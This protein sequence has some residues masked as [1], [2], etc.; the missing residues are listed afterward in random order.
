MPKA[1][2]LY[3]P[4]KSHLLS[5]SNCFVVDD[6]VAAVAALGYKP[7]HAYVLVRRVGQ[8][9][10]D[11]AAEMALFA[12][13][14][15]SLA[16]YV[17]GSQPF[18]SASFYLALHML[19]P[20]VLCAIC[21]VIEMLLSAV[22]FGKSCIAVARNDFRNTQF[23]CNKDLQSLVQYYI[24]FFVVS[25]VL[26]VHDLPLHRYLGHYVFCLVFRYGAVYSF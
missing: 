13:R 4:Q 8:P 24:L 5:F 16:V 3:T 19:K 12:Y 2:L 21:A 1:R 9:V 10:F 26:D 6:K 22:P 15:H 25:P 23:D 17:F 20:P 7:E 11:Y 18:G 14:A